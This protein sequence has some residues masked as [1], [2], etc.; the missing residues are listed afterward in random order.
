MQITSP[1]SGSAPSAALMSAVRT[2]LLLVVLLVLAL[3]GALGAAPASALQVRVPATAIDDAHR[4]QGGGT[5][6]L[7]K[8]TTPE[9]CG[10][11]GGGCARGYQHGIIL[12]SPATGAQAV[13]GAVLGSYLQQG[14]EAGALGYP[15]GAKACALRDGGCWQPF[16]RGRIYWKAGPGAHPVNG[17][18][19]TAWD[20]QKRMNGPL[21]YPMTDKACGPGWCSQSFERGRIGWTP[22]GGT[23]TYRDIDD[24]GSLTVLVNKRKPL[25]P[26]GHQPAD[27]RTST[28]V[29]LRDPAAD[30]WERM[31]AAAATQGVSLTAVSG[32]R[33]SATQDSLYRGYVAQY[34][35]AQADLISARPGFS[36][37]QTG[38]ALDIG[39]PDGACGLQACFETT[40]AGRWARDNAWR[41][42]FIVRYPKGLTNVTGYAYEPWHLRYVGVGTARSVR[43]SGK[44]TYEGYLSQPWAPSY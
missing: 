39:N 29:T 23:R 33:S 14:R 11:V 40:P 30:A 1:R 41:H 38:L 20:Q 43:G 17:A 3:T 15:T 12:W 16:Q 4:A 2:T 19:F 24:P 44:A 28:G 37:H 9:R 5:G 13:G 22:Q 18:T 32:Y 34:G 35:R 21:G 36:E 10:L 26:R 7:G 27:L 6:P 8:P 42:G 31:R 25:N